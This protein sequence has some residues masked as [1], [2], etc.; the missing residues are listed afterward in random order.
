MD[1]TNQAQRLD[2]PRSISLT[3]VLPCGKNVAPER[4]TPHERT[5]RLGI[6]ARKFK[7]EE[8]AVEDVLAPEMDSVLEN[9]ELAF[10]TSPHAAY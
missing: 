10:L 6:G 5:A 1:S 2:N 4:K 8:R 3:Q 7:F 9:V